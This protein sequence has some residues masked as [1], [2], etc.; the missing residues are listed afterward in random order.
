MEDH[1]VAVQYGSP[2]KL[3]AR[4]WDRRISRPSSQVPTIV[5]AV[6]L[7]RALLAFWLS[8]FTQLLAMTFQEQVGA[9]ARFHVGWDLLLDRLLRLAIIHSVVLALA[10]ILHAN[11]HG[12][13]V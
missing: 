1:F 8:A 13:I 6:S 10:A 7:N 3:S 9:L 11:N 2:S 5:G 4:S 12:R